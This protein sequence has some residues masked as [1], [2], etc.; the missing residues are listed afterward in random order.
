LKI[1]NGF[2]EFGAAFE[3]VYHVAKGKV[4]NAECVLLKQRELVDF[5][6]EWLERNG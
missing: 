3:N 5:T 2:P 6:L 1:S 4:G